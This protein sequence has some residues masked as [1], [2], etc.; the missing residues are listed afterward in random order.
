MVDQFV[1]GAER[2]PL[3]QAMER[4]ELMRFLGAQAALSRRICSV[5]SGAFCWQRPDC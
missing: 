1:P 2:G 4:P 5:C 3:L